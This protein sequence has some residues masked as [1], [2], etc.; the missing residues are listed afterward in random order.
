MSAPEQVLDPATLCDEIDRIVA[1]EPAS[2]QRDAVCALLAET[3]EARRAAVFDYLIAHP[4]AGLRVA[5]SLAHVMD[6]VVNAC[7]H[8][9]ATH[10][11]PAPVRT[12]AQKLAVVAVGGYGRGE[13]APFSDVDL[14]LLTP[15]KQTAWGESVIESMLY[16]LWDLKLKVGHSVRSI[17]DCLRYAQ[18]DMTVRTALLEMRFICGDREPYDQAE[19]KLRSQL[20]NQTAG[21][22]VEAKLAERDE[23]HK[24]HGGSRYMVEP[25]IKEGKGGLRDLQTLHWVSK[26]VY[27]CDTAWD[28]VERGIYSHDEVQ[29]FADAAKFIW[30]VRAHLHHLNGRAQEVLSFDR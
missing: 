12:K 26:Y 21:E 13:M 29:K 20:F 27:T 5:R 4:C 18:Q 9:C 6:G 24:R 17:G 2:K 23:R 7:H 10:L 19:A 3:M 1:E 22:Y 14:L 16:I 15:H 25:N 30:A 28:L 11:H 8:Y